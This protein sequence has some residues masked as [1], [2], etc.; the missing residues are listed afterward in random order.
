[1][2]YTIPTRETPALV[3]VRYT[4]PALQDL[5][6]LYLRYHQLPCQTPAQISRYEVT[7]RAGIQLAEDMLGQLLLPQVRTYQ[8]Y[9]G[10]YPFPLGA[11]TVQVGE[12]AA[13]AVNYL[14]YGTRHSLSISG[15]YSTSTRMVLEKTAAGF[16]LDALNTHLPFIYDC[17]AKN[18]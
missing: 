5:A 8:G 15:S 7:V 1:M 6:E 10:E 13:Q 3:S 9:P 18:A 11:T 17:I 14:S 16:S 12:E 4:P 2:L